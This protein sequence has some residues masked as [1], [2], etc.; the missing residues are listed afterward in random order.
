MLNTKPLSSCFVRKT[1]RIIEIIETSVRL[2]AGPHKF[3]TGIIDL[4]HGTKFILHATLKR[5]DESRQLQQI[6][7]AEPAL[8]RCQRRER[9]FR[10]EVSPVQ[11]NL[12]L[13]ALLVEKAYSEFASMFFP[14]EFFKHTTAERMKW[15]R[16]P[17]LLCV[18]S[19]I[20]CSAT[21]LLASEYRR[22]FQIRATELEFCR[23]Q[24][25]IRRH[26]CR[27]QHW[28]ATS[29]SG[30]GPIGPASTSTGRNFIPAVSPNGK[31]ARQISPGFIYG[32][33]IRQSVNVLTCVAQLVTPGA[34]NVPWPKGARLIFIRPDDDQLDTSGRDISRRFGPDLMVMV[35]LA[36]YAD[37]SHSVDLPPFPQQFATD[38]FTGGKVSFS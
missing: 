7:G 10:R 16:D 4:T 25:Q 30:T 2:A 17:K 37:G 23:I 34:R 5:L 36:Y 1:P 9:V 29:T 21:P 22:G 20:A 3:T 33:A 19:T 35:D 13:A 11:R 12:A 28:Y 32:L 38:G 18:Y 24:N 8:A 26:H 15:M 31:L 27:R 6:C 14:T